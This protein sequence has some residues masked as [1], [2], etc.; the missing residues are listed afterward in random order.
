[1]KAKDHY[2]SLL[3]SATQDVKRLRA[4]AKRGLDERLLQQH[5]KEVGEQIWER[6]LSPEVQEILEHR[7]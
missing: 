5:I 3:L 7:G 4:S 6:L 2:A 1:M